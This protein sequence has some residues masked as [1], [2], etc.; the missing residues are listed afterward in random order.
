MAHAYVDLSLN[1]NRSIYDAMEKERLIPT[2]QLQEVLSEK[3][4]GLSLDGIPLRT[5]S[6]VVKSAI[7]EALGY[8]TPKSFTKTHPRFPAQNFDTY[9][10]K[11]TNL[12]IW[13][14][15]IDP[16]R[17]YVILRVDGSST[18]A[19]IKIIT[20]AELSLLDHTGKL[21]QKYQATMKQF[22]CDRLFS[23]A[24]TDNVAGWTSA[25]PSGLSSALPTAKPTEGSLLPI[26]EIYNRLLP[27]SGTELNYLDALQ[28]RNRGSELHAKICKQ[29][30]YSSYADDGEYPD[31]VHQLIEVKLQTSPTI[32]LGLHSPLDGVTVVATGE[33]KFT[34]EDIRYVV[35]DGSV[36]ADKI[37]LNALYV[38][39]GKDFTKAFPLFQGKVV[40]K[41]LQIPLPKGFFD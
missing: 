16:A 13:N 18:I 19:Q 15:P 20:G 2:D 28:E 32:D 24:D 14:E 30:G 41:K 34:S 5:R 27:L 4:V 17:R 22:G 26:S 36:T 37:R 8:P 33:K 9:T 31:I 3:L 25:T 12:Q 11:S 21:T 6:R 7:C 23:S 35:F 39:S 40:N 38:V 29:L 1:S 10:Q